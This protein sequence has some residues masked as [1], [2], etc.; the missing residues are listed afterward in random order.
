MLTNTARTAC[1]TGARAKA[2]CLPQYWGQGESLV[3]NRFVRNRPKS[4]K[5]QGAG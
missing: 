2:W 4:P 3:P 1:N 5:I